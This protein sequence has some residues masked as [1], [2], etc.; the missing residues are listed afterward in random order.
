VGPKNAAKELVE[1]KCR[2]TGEASLSNPDLAIA[3][4]EGR[5]NVK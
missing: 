3:E 5:L 2:Q 4:V 1:L